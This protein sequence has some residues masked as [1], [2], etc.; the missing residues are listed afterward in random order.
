M[1]VPAHKI[2]V[3]EDENIVAMDLRATLTRLGYEV[4]DTVGTGRQ[5]IE[6]VERQHPDLVLMDIQ[7]RGDMDGV[8][9]A[10]RIRTLHVP[11]VYLTA[12]SDDAT[13]RRARETGPHGYVLKPFD[14][15]ELQIVIELGIHRHRA[16]EE[17]DQLL[18]EQAA[19]AA[20][21][22]EHRWSRFL[23]DASRELSKS[24]DL[25]VTFET[26]VRLA[27][28]DL[29]DWAALH[30]RVEHGDELA[31]VSHAY[32]KEEALRE[33]LRRYPPAP[34]L[35]HGYPH[36]MRT[37]AP[38]LIAE[39]SEEL[40][41]SVAADAENLRLL[42][43]LML[44]SQ[45]CVPLVIRGENRAALTLAF[46]ESGRRYGPEDVTRAIELASRCAVTMENAQL[47][48][49]AEEA[50]GVR[51]EFLSVA[52][53]ELRTPLSTIQLILQSVERGA[54]KLDSKQLVSKIERVLRQVDRL[55]ELVKNLLDVTRI[56]AGQLLLEVDEFDFVPVVREIVE[57]F[58]EPAHS[59]ASPLRV[60][61]PEVLVVRADRLR[62]DQVI[63]NLL[64]NAIKFGA[65]KPVDV[66]LQGGESRFQLTVRDRGIGIAPEHLSRIFNRF[67]RAVSTRHYGGL[68][69]GLYITRR[70]VEAHGG[71][72]HVE[73]APGAGAAFTVNLP[74]KA[75]AG[76]GLAA[77]A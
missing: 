63:T 54:R 17:H 39:F 65:G 73:S 59:A 58:A 61:F 40:L 35:P 36:V 18:R 26:I 4:V 45:I 30:V 2:L 62:L 46:A 3:V 23:G 13:L 49:Q 56:G 66:T 29:A 34:H 43:M 53:H 60:H 27:V 28:P 42:R 16:Q 47:F 25:Q 32:G 22:K 67:E 15:R 20:I 31:A 44:K 19:R 52:S 5:A 11:V 33:L 64:S 7:L 71:T 1:K 37:G 57:R 10:E 14:D 74:R 70:I 72:V 12:F 69:L 8:E 76:K 75:I 21:E 55:T 6:Q 50:I 51:D 41:A 9:A 48:R 68:G 24:L 38:E 77:N